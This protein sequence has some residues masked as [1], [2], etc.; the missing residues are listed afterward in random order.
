MKKE[1]IWD[2]DGIFN[3]I[4]NANNYLHYFQAAERVAKLCGIHQLSAEEIS[5]R[6]VASMK[7]EHKYEMSIDVLVYEFGVNYKKAHD[8]IHTALLEDHLKLY[9]G[10]FELAKNFHRIDHL[11]NH[12]ATHSNEEWTKFWLEYLDISDSI[13]KIFYIKDLNMCK[14]KH[15]QTYPYILHAINAKPDECCMID[16]SERNL[17]PAFKNGI[18]PI[19]FNT[20]KSKNGFESYDCPIKLIDSLKAA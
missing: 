3:N 17:I 5:Q 19:L 11:N 6:W 14:F 7:T 4:P 13:N 16:D 9:K 18:K 10:N 2:L 20:S 8:L 15:E 1:I 12:I